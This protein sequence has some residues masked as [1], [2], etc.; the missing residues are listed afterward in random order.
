MKCPYCSNPDT[1][2]VD[3]RPT[4]DNVSI[5]RRRSCLKCN[6]RF[7]TYERY[8]EVPLI[9]IKKDDTR[10]P[11]DRN[12]IFNGMLRSCEKRPVSVDSIEKATTE[13]EQDLNNLNQREVSSLVI[14]EMVMD[15]LRELDK[16][17]YVRFASVYREFQDVSRFYD[18][19][20]N[21]K[22]V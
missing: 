20:E 12:K 14:G 3:S 1:K 13:I 17:A 10:E 6:K 11:F 21:L 16:V 2:V 18:E 9:V 19:L 22:D 4:E 15:K 5:R 7:T 8:E